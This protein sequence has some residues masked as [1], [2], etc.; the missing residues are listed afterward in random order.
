MKNT[1]V[2]IVLLTTLQFFGQNDQKT[3]FQKC[4]Y[5]LAVSYYQKADF[6]KAIDLFSLA[7]KIKPENEIGQESNKKVDTLREVL[8]KEIL[9]HAIG[10]WKKS[11]NQ[12]VWA[13]TA[14]DANNQS[15]VDEVLEISETEISF[16]EMDKKTKEKKLLKKEDLIYNDQSNTASLFS[17]IILSDG[18]IWNC[19][20]NEKADVL[21]V[22]NVAVKTENGIEK[23][24]NDNEESYYV[25]M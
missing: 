24:N 16:Y 2:L 6:V 10:S 14:V 12:P 9:D 11:G 17:E 4:K 25:K 19:S 22:I 7:A 5:E 21:R 20:V 8:R 18:T 15:N 23:I 1:F 3:A 13:S